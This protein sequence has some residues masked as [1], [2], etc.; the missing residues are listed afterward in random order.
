MGTGFVLSTKALVFIIGIFFSMVVGLVTVILRVEQPLAPAA[1][2]CGAA[3]G[4]SMF[5]WIAAMALWSRR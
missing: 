1:L 5:L 2:V 4:T 3:F